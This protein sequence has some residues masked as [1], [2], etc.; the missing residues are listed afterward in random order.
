MYGYVGGGDDD[1]DDGFVVGPQQA[2]ISHEY[3]GKRGFGG[4]FGGS[5]SRPKSLRSLLRSWIR[6]KRKWWNRKSPSF[7]RR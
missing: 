2:V 4:G 1:D 3:I 5:S 6:S 7:G